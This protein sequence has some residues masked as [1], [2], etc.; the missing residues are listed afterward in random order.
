LAIKNF[1]ELYWKL[2]NIA[3][4]GSE[5]D[6]TKVLDSIVKSDRSKL[7]QYFTSSVDQIAFD[8]QDWKRMRAFF[9]DLF[10]AHR[11]LITQAASISD[12]H[13]LTNS[14]LDELFRSFGYPE[15]VRLQGFDENPLENKVQLFLDLVNLY[16]IKGT[17]RSI[18]EVLQ[19]YGIPELD[20]FEFWLQKKSQGELEFRGEAVAGTTLDPSPI[21][22]PFDLLTL[23]DPHWMMSESKVLQL[24]ALNKINLP[25]KTPYFAVQPSVEIGIENAIL[26]RLVQDQFESWATT[27]NL[28]PQD[29]DITILG[30][31]SSLLE[32]YLLTLYSFHKDYE[33]GSDINRFACYDGTNTTT[34]DIV[35]EYESIISGPIT[36]ANKDPKYQQYIDLFT[37]ARDEHFLYGPQTAETT[38]NMINPQLITDL[39]SLTSDNATALQSLLKDLAVWVRNNI[40]FGF[41][42]LGYIFFGLNQLFEDLKPVIKFFKPYRARLVVLELLNFRNQLTESIPMEDSIDGFTIDFDTYDYMTADSA[43]CCTENIDTT[44]NICLDTTAGT[45]YSRDTYDCGSY[46]DIGAVDDITPIEI[47]IEQNICDAFRCP[48]GCPSDS[49]DTSASTY[50]DVCDRLGS[51]P[52]PN[53]DGTSAMIIAPDSTDC[54]EWLPMTCENAPYV[55]SETITDTLEHIEDLVIGTE[56]YTVLFPEEEGSSDYILNV[57]LFNEWVG[58]LTASMYGIIITQKSKSGF[59]IAFSSPLDRLDYKLSWSV[60]PS[61]T[62]R[63]TEVLTQGSDTYTVTFGTPFTGTDYA[64]GTSMV[65]VV[66]S[67]PS[68]YQFIVT[69]KDENGFTMQFNSPIDSTNYT[70]DWN[71]FDSTSYVPNGLV[72]IPYGVDEFTVYYPS[73]N[74]QQNDIYALSLTMINTEDTTASVYSYLL[75]RK[76]NNNFTIAF[77]SPIDSTNYYLSYAITHKPV[78]EYLY[79]QESG[80]RLYDT[81]G[82]FDCTHGFDSVEVEVQV[83]AQQG[84]ILQ[85]N[86]GWL[87]LEDGGGILW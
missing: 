24:D 49:T 50:Q 11:S 9:I 13:F 20:I 58:G 83:L 66:D 60:N 78:E 46:H 39:D 5:S 34:V 32:L 74:K 19:Y 55:F 75:T 15:S 27:G 54:S 52:P 8:T 73:E 84:V 43:P 33:V 57:N 70:I 64:I 29:A 35:A 18:L 87:L 85:E 61:A 10:S 72:N 48:P 69:E 12:P 7:D 71:I 21:T 45:F 81:M 23:G 44:S 6:V 56:S 17:P 79:R 40:G 25:S 26:V 76:D 41:V 77:S 86:D 42:N 2:F 51:I 62:N 68:M 47:T 37:R 38:L 36:R 22:L 1:T 31:T 4:G 67:P 28:P 14:E 30:V 16:K 3:G 59:T 53:F 80:F 65:N 82:T 63:G